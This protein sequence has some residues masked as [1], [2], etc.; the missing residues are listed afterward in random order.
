MAAVP[1]ST[2]RSFCEGCAFTRSFQVP[3]ALL[4]RWWP[5]AA[6]W[7]P[8]LLLQPRVRRRTRRAIRFCPCLEVVRVPG[9]REQSGALQRPAAGHAPRRSDAAATARRDRWPRSPVLRVR[10]A[11]RAAAPAETWGM[12]PTC[13]SI[14]W[15]MMHTSTTRRVRSVR[16]EGRGVS[17][18]YGTWGMQPTC[19]SIS[20]R[21]VILRGADSPDS[22]TSA[23]KNLSRCARAQRLTSRSFDTP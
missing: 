2:H 18:Q 13:K 22:R 16:E 15:L 10:C 21:S 23:L 4:A 19:K 20:W 14:S 17:S 6:Q 8:Q 7:H 9:Q 3:T 11:T 12:Q 5:K 1:P